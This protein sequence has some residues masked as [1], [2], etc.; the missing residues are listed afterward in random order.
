MTYITGL[1]VNHDDALM[2]E[3]FVM[4]G[5]DIDGY[6]RDGTTALLRAGYSLKHA[7]VHKRVHRSLS[8]ITIAQLHT[9][10]SD[11][12][13]G[14]LKMIQLQDYFMLSVTAKFFKVKWGLLFI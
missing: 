2:V 1:A 11:I 8:L 7:C 9:R 12:G 3:S 6:D 5:A 4:R 10:A 14:W 13:V